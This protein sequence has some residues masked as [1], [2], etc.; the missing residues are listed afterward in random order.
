[1][2]FIIRNLPKSLKWCFERVPPDI[3]S[4]ALEHIKN[5]ASA[6]ACNLIAFKV[7]E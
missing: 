5:T 4:E 7:S 3:G 2:Y 6:Y 1:M